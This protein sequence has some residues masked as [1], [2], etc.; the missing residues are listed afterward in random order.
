[1]NIFLWIGVVSLALAA[2]LSACWDAD[3]IK[4]T[5][6]QSYVVLE[7]EQYERLVKAMEETAQNTKRMTELLETKSK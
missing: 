7:T 2:M 6:D 3:Y 4:Y 5:S 1:M